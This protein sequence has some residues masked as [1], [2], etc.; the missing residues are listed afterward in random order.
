MLYIR[1]AILTIVN[2][3]FTAFAISLTPLVVL[4]A[5]E[6]GYLPNW[7]VWFQTQDNS[8]D[9]GWRGTYFGNP[10]SPAPKGFELWKYRIRWL[11]RNPAYGFCYWPLGIQMKF[12]DWIIDDYK[13][14]TSGSRIL[15]K[16]HTITGKHFAYTTNK[17]DKYGWKIWAYFRGLDKDGKAVWNDKPWGP[18]MRTSLCF[19]PRNPFKK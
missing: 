19:T 1:Y 7:L 15:L 10:V 11:W 2:L 8:L 9:E 6:Q 17:G 16:A 3:V 12:E 5:N 18:E 13:E 4:F 14:D